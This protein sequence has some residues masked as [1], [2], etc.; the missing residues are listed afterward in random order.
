[1]S[2]IVQIRTEVRDREA[3]AR[4]CDRLKLPA[5]TDGTATL[6]Q[7]KRTGTIVRLP[8]W[9]YPV[10]CDTSTGEVAY[11]NFEGTWG[12]IDRLHSFM[13]AYSVEKASLEARKRG[14]SV[15]EQPLADGSIKLLIGVAEGGR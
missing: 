1:M 4:A 13:Q 11:D 7:A 14:H 8:E 6:F 10:V 12:P 5:P 2:H 9:Q 3:I 15:I